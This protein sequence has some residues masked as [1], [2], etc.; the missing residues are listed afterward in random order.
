MNL[1][2]RLRSDVLKIAGYLVSLVQ[3][4]P[5]LGVWIPLMTVPFIIYLFFFFTTLPNSLIASFLNFGFWFFIIGLFPFVYSMIYLNIK[6]KEGLVTKGPYGLVRHPQYLILIL[7]TMIL[8]VLSYWLL[9][10]TLG[11]GFFSAPMTIVVWCAELFAYVILAKIEELH[12]SKSF[13]ASYEDYKSHVPFMIP[14][15]KTSRE[16][17]DI[18]LSIVFLASLLFGFIF[19]TI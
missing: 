5:S 17:V 4:M 10:H 6:K 2:E 14:F 7:L 19:I 11:I 3:S 13:N 9:T 18:I 12:L 15:L 1:S 8:T 16:Y